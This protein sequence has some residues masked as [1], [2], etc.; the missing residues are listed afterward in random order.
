MYR[1]YLFPFCVFLSAHLTISLP[2]SVD[3]LHVVVNLQSVLVKILV[4]ARVGRSMLT[5]HWVQ[6]LLLRS[7]ADANRN[8]EAMR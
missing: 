1:P 7:E 4:A 8:R 2:L 3:A 5:C 6:L